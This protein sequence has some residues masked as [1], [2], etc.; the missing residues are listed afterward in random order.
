MKALRTKQE[1]A[2]K[3]PVLHQVKLQPLAR[4]MIRRIQSN[5]NI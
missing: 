5:S 2:H 1:P 4:R 3:E